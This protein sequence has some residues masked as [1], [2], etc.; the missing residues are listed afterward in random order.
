MV[1]FRPTPPRVYPMN[2]A[3]AVEELVESMKQN[4]KG[5]PQAP[6]E[7]PSALETYKLD[8]ETSDVWQFV[9]IEQLFAYLRKSKKLRIPEEWTPFVPKTL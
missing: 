2:F 5:Q 6:Q 4:K 1:N 7:L 8:W 3:F 9:N